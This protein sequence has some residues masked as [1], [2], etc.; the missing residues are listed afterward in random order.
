M[1]LNILAGLF[2]VIV[3]LGLYSAGTWSAFRRGG[4][5]RN[6][7]ILLWTGVGFDIL[8]TVMMGLSIGGLDLSPTGWLHTTIALL[9]WALMFVSVLTGTLAYVRRDEVLGLRTSRLILGP[10]AL[11]VAVF[12]W[13]M[14]A[15]GPRG[16]A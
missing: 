5:G 13:G 11:W 9:A 12:V 14:I 1:P 3:A 16:P 6:Q 8:A 2:C 7:L 4:F 15:R 10:W